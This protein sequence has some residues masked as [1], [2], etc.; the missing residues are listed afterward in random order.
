MNT[1]VQSAETIKIELKTNIKKITEKWHILKEDSQRQALA[2]EE[3]TTWQW[4]LHS[5]NALT[6]VNT[7]FT[8]QYALH[9]DTI[10]V[11]SLS[12]N[13]KKLSND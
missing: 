10:E 13:K 5:P 3:L 11:K 6:A 8:T 9:A 1:F 7:T 12:R 2:R 4:L